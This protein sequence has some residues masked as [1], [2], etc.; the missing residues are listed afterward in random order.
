MRNLGGRYNTNQ[1]EQFRF[2]LKHQ[3]LEISEKTALPM[4][5]GIYKTLDEVVKFELG[6]SNS[7]GMNLGTS[8]YHFDNL[9]VSEKK[10]MK[11]CRNT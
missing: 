11:M 1:M 2:A 6:G 9:K 8:N 10:K 3:P 7:I 5:N 4:H